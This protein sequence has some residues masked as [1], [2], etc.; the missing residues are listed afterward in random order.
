MSLNLG[1]DSKFRVRTTTMIAVVPLISFLFTWFL[2]WIYLKF[3]FIFFKSHLVQGAKL[4]YQTFHDFVMAELPNKWF[5]FVGYL[6]LIFAF[7]IYFSGLMLRPFRKIEN[8]CQ[9]I[10]LGKEDVNFSLSGL[11]TQQLIGKIG[12]DFF[13]FFKEGKKSGNF[14]PR[15]PYADYEK[16]TGP[17]SDKVNYIQYFSLLMIVALITSVILYVAEVQI[18]DAVVRFSDSDSIKPA[19]DNSIYLSFQKQILNAIFV[20]AV[21]FLP[22]LYILIC[23]FIVKQVNGVS[24]AYFRDMRDILKGRFQKRITLR[25]DDPGKNGAYLFNRVMDMHLK[26]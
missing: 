1:L 12:R 17:S 22:L 16:I 26:G 19:V 21:A 6:L 7:G 25:T 14:T 10:L 24:Y 5:F 3:N 9:E 13:D 18:Y 8:V 2:T 4:E 15:Q 11:E 23:N 20:F